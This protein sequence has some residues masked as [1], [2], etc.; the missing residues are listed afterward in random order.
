M[1]VLNNNNNNNN[2]GD[3]D[4]DDDDYDKSLTNTKWRKSHSRIC[5]CDQLWSANRLW[6][7]VIGCDQLWS[8][9]HVQP[10]SMEICRM[11]KLKAPGK[12]SS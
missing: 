1:I 7:A 5:G 11:A 3:D 8:L 10:Q 6:S 2:N 9:I 4:D 12:E